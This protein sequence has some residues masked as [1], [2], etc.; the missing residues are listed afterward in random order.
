MPRK[1]SRRNRNRG[2]KANAGASTEAICNYGKLPNPFQLPL[3]RGSEVKHVD[4]TISAYPVSTTP[5]YFVATGIS[6]GTSANTRLGNV[7][8]IKM[9]QVELFAQVADTTNFVKTYLICSPNGQAGTPGF[10]NWSDPPDSDQYIILED[11]LTSLQ[12]ALNDTSCIK[13]K[14]RFPGQGLLVRWD[15]SVGNSEILN[16][17]A[18]CLISD[19]SAAP[20]PTVYGYIRTYFTDA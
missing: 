12:T 5:P 19:S 10:G 13:M 2:R 11:R 8:L 14:H 18:L 17:L 1:S 6:Q 9:I 15:S 3:F 20:H 7:A 16:R 4:Y